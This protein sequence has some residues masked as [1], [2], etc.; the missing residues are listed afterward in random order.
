MT[1][2]ELGCVHFLWWENTNLQQ[3]NQKHAAMQCSNCGIKIVESK[4]CSHAVFKI[5]AR[6]AILKNFWFVFDADR[7]CM[8]LQKMALEALIK[9]SELLQPCECLCRKPVAM[10]GV[11]FLP[12]PGH[13]K[14]R[15]CAVS[16]QTI[17]LTKTKNLSVPQSDFCTRESNQTQESKKVKLQTAF[18]LPL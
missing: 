9:T 1:E 2:P 18:S 17:K 14:G 15:S 16:H 11:R 3:K 10:D 4:T 8:T 5:V 6:Y 13:N 7:L 12:N